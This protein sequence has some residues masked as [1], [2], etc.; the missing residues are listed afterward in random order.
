MIDLVD[1]CVAAGLILSDT[2]CYGYKV[3]PILGGKYNI[4]NVEPRDLSVHDSF[5]ADIWRQT[6]ELPDGTEVKLVVLK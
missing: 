2:Q 6:R 5:L 4:E 3:P 1:R